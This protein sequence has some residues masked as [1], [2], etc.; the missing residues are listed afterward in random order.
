MKDQIA[1]LSVWGNDG[2]DF[3]K[4][5][6]EGSAVSTHFIITAL[7]LNKQDIPAVETVF[8]A[9]ANKYFEDGVIDS[10]IIDN[11]HEL[12]KVIL[13]DILSEPLQI[14]A[15]VVDKRQLIGEGL[16]YKGSVHKF[17]HGLADRELYSLFP[18]LEM[19][20]NPKA[21]YGFM[22]GFIKFVH[23]NHIPNLFNQST[24]GFVNTRS[25]V[26]IQAASF[27]AGTLARCYDDTVVTDQRQDFVQLIQPA[28]IT[29]KFWPDVFAPYVV[30]I[31][32]RE[33]RYSEEL[34]KMSLNLANDF[35]NR[36]TGNQTPHVVDQLA[37]LSYLVF[38]FRHINPTRYISSFEIMEH[39][40]V[41]RGK[42][43]SLHYFQT[44]VIAPLRDAGV[45]IASSSR[46]YKLPASERDLYDFINHSN[47][48]VEPMLARIKKFRDQISK[49][50]KGKLDVLGK[51]EYAVIR[52]VLD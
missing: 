21:D 12:R 37:C 28:L 46:G 7:L 19:V 42:T 49:A 29:M 16:R 10:Q 18:N 11:N 23:H 13:S 15:L 38:H 26:I 32:A 33:L 34:S 45:L 14:F 1:F 40:R 41:R 44:K 31:N 39:I 48:I 30:K 2:L 36:K 9:A 5:Q 43:V 3:S 24:F 51:N 4:R 20:G 6:L 8:E 35:I 25:D 52:K 50:T 27:L 17:L 47:T 22:E